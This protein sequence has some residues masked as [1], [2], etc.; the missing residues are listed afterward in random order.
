M[1]VHGPTVNGRIR[2]VFPSRNEPQVVSNRDAVC[3]KATIEQGLAV[4]L[5]VLGDAVQGIK[6]VLDL[7][8]IGVQHFRIID[9][10]VGGVNRKLLEP[11]EDFAHFI[12]RTLGGL[13]E[14]DRGR[15][16]VVSLLQPHDPPPEPFRG[17]QG[18][19]PIG[20]LVDLHPRA[21]LLDASLHTLHGIVGMP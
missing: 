18:S 11:N 5:R 16:V 15:G 13:H 8:L 6:Q 3:P 12:E 2:S 17:D 10:L 1:D 20:P 4:E 7:H 19:W 14:R 9:R 21:K